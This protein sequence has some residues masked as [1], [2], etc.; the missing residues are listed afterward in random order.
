VIFERHLETMRVQV[1][2]HLQTPID[3]IE[4]T[5]NLMDIVEGLPP[6]T[7]IRLDEKKP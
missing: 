4:F 2:M 6:V 7:R 1:E 5:L 3:R